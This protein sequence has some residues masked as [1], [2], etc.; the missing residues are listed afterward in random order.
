[1]RP[2]LA[3]GAPAVLEFP[4]YGSAKIDG[5][6]AVVRHGQVLTR[7]LELIPNRYVQQCLALPW[8]EGLDGELC[9]G[10]PYDEHLFSNTQSGVLSIEGRPDFR[11]YVFDY[12]NA[13]AESTPYRV[14]YDRLLQAFALPSFA[15]HPHLILLEQR[16]V[17]D[18]EQLALMQ[19][20]HIERGYEGLILRN[21]SGTYKFGRSTDNLS[22]AV[23]AKSGQ[24][25]QPWT[26][27]KVKKYS[28]GE[29]RVVGTVEMYHN[30]NE[31]EDSPLG[32]AKR[33]K[34]QEGMVPAGVLGALEC[35]DLASG[36]KFKLGS[37]FTAKQRA[38]YWAAR[39]SLIGLVARYKH[40]EPGAVVAPRHGVFQGFLDPRDMGE[41]DESRQQAQGPIL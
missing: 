20:D 10:N 22:T 40:F 14:R 38:D 24:P 21:L 25:L 35:E 18:M 1:M 30:E 7:K 33:G 8:L 32:L 15:S 39:G 36:V 26:M 34:S 41:P 27:L 37:G 29:A 12:W 2:M 17:L 19:E 31:L 11:F 3:A 6:R 16:P 28:T 23:H 13:D 9:V 4:V 5:V